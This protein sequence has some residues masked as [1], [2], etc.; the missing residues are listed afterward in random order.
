MAGLPDCPVPLGPFLLQ[1]KLRDGVRNT[2]GQSRIVTAELNGDDPR[3]LLSV[4]RQPFEKIVGYIGAQRFR[5]KVFSFFP[6]LHIGAGIETE[7]LPQP[8]I[9][10]PGPA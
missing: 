4:D 2:G 1:E 5:S 6:A 7:I 8:V 3:Q 10:R 9:G